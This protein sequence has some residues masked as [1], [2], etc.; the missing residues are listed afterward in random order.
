MERNANTMI[1]IGQPDAEPREV[2]TVSGPESRLVGCW[3]EGVHIRTNTI[4]MLMG[5]FGQLK[6]FWKKELSLLDIHF[7]PATMQAVCLK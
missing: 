2:I 6:L 1:A 5:D 4:N 3:D 7:A